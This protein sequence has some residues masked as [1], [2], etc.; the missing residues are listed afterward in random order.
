MYAI[1]HLRQVGGFP[2]TQMTTTK[3]TL[4]TNT[5]TLQLTASDNSFGIFR[6]TF[7]TR[8]SINLH[9]YRTGQQIMNIQCM[10]KMKRK[11]A[12]Q[13]KQNI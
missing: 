3:V 9:T 10:F 13:E 6:H 4:N 2:P 8:C 1:S 5:L 7:L 11:L 12:I